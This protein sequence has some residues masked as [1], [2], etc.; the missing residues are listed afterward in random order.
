VTID[1]AVERIH[2]AY[3]QI[4]FACHTRHERRRST[5]HQLSMRDSQILAHLDRKTPT[6]VTALARHLGLAAS[7]LS[8][9]IKT[10]AALGYVE[11]TAGASRDRRAV[12]LRLT[13]H[14]VTA[15]RETSVLES[16]R[17][18][19]ALRRLNPADRRRAVDGLALFADA[20]R[21]RS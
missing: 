19:A 18:A 14:G 3:P 2:F 7:T 16:P 12:G 17:L 8:E 15:V 5:A 10:L 20:C 4:Y 21:R 1:Q 11:K 9:A 6:N 13:D